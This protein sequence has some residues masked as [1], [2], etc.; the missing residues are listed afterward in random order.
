MCSAKPILAHF[1]RF[2]QCD[3]V[4]LCCVTNQGTCVG[5][6]ET[7]SP[8]E[9]YARYRCAYSDFGQNLS[10]E[11]NWEP[12]SC[13]VEDWIG[14][15]AYGS[16]YMAVIEFGADKDDEDVYE[17]DIGTAGGGAN[18]EDPVVIFT[19]CGDGGLCNCGARALADG[20]QFLNAF[21]VYDLHDANSVV[22]LIGCS[23]LF[24]ID[25]P[26]LPETLDLQSD[27][28][29][30]PFR[31]NLYVRGTS[32]DF[33]SFLKESTPICIFDESAPTWILKNKQTNIMHRICSR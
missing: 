15:G 23:L 21:T 18:A 10:T 3:I 20:K 19:A 1:S 8:Q 7:G 24:L 17:G 33:A 25:A 29:K 26:V 22:R 16:M 5:E 27:D 4:Q 2:D 11:S 31:I 30:Y 13:S 28:V 12:I 14:W 6:N 9:K 32:F